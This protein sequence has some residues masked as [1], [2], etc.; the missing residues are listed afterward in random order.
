MLEINIWSYAHLG[1]W[2]FFWWGPLCCLPYLF[3][4]VYV[5]N[6][7]IG[8]QLRHLSISP[9][10]LCNSTSS[11]SLP[12]LSY[13]W[14]FCSLLFPLLLDPVVTLHLFGWNLSSHLSDHSCKLSRSFSRQ[15]CGICLGFNFFIDFCIVRK[16]IWL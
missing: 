5:V 11:C 1:R 3:S 10:E 13:R 12:S 2:M 8:H 15:T 14:Y 9:S 6:N 4:V 7:L 16:N